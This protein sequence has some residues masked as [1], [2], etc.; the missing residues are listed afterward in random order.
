MTEEGTRKL[1]SRSSFCARG[2][3]S[4]RGSLTAQES[5]RGLALL[6]REVNISNAPRNNILALAKK[7]TAADLAISFY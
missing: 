1:R 7:A 6:Y 4:S 2:N 5:T 3:V